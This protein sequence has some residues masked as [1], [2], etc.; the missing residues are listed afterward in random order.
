MSPRAT[1]HSP[2]VVC[3]AFNTVLPAQPVPLPLT[4][5]L[6]MTVH[7]SRTFALNY[8]N[9]V[10]G[11]KYIHNSVYISYLLFWASSLPLHVYVSDVKVFCGLVCGP[12]ADR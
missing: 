12:F 8:L 2:L 5:H 1:I 7:A 3:I 10:C 4:K 6:G 11:R 9:K